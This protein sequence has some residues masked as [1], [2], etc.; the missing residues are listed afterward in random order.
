MKTPKERDSIDLLELVCQLHSRSLS[1]GTKETHDAYVEARQALE[2]RITKLTNQSKWILVS[3]RLPERDA[4]DSWNKEH[5]ISAQILLYMSGTGVVY[6]RYYG[7]PISPHFQVTGY[8][9]FDQSRI[10]HW[11]PLPEPPN[12]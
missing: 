8:I 12:T 4:L 6:G 10:T 7:N 11:M 1:T 3:E 2:S 5:N 9:G